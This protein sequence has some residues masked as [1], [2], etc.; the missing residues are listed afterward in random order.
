[1]GSE[2]LDSDMYLPKHEMRKLACLPQTKF[3]N[4]KSQPLSL[5]IDLAL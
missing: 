3:S 1:M 4:H 5:S 2:D